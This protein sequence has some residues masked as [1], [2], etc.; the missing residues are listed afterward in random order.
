MMLSGVTT[1]SSVKLFAFKLPAIYRN[2]YQACL[3]ALN[4]MLAQNR[5]SSLYYKEQVAVMYLTSGKRRP[6]Q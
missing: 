5:F 4:S 6:W 2:A 1:Q 3:L